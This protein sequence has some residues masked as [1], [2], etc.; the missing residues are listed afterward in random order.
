M[1]Y[2]ITCWFVHASSW[3]GSR[4]IRRA[5]LSTPHHVEGE[6]GW[7]WNGG[8]GG[9]GQGGRQRCY[10]PYTV[11]GTNVVDNADVPPRF[12]S[13]LVERQVLSPTD[14]SVCTKHG[15]V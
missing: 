8:W 15:A 1:G 10:K 5:L 7:G 14:S 9:G 2:P 4:T 12:A 11:G 6:G 3:A 13:V